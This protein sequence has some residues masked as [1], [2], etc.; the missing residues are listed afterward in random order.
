MNVYA[1]YIPKSRRG[2][3]AARLLD[4]PA[5]AVCGRYVANICA[6]LTPDLAAKLAYALDP[7]AALAEEADAMD[8][9][10][11]MRAQVQRD[12]SRIAWYAAR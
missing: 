4:L 8:R 6:H 1:M 3:Q 9:A 11:K 7:E 10:A 5:R 12:A 2:R